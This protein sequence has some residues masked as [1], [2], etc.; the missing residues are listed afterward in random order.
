MVQFSIEFDRS[1]KKNRQRA[2]WFMKQ[3]SVTRV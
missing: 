3:K 1:V 2:V